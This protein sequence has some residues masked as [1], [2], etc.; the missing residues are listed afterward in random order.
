MKVGS[1]YETQGQ[2]I[3]GVLHGYCVYE[4]GDMN[5]SVRCA[6]ADL[7]NLYGGIIY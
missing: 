3:E 2:I 6:A 4:T 5:S 1:F 7:G